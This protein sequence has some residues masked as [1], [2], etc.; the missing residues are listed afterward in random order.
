MSRGAPTRF[1]RAMRYVSV[2]AVAVLVG[3]V[4]FTEAAYANFPH[5]RTFEVSLTG[6]ALTGIAASDSGAEVAAAS[7]SVASPELPDLLFTWTEVGVGQPDVV[8]LLQSEVTA[9]FGCVNA[10][11]KLP[12]AGNKITVAA[13][14]ATE[15]TLT[16][17]RNG[18]ISGSVVLDT[19]SVF[20][21]GFSCPS[22]Q[23]LVALSA[24][25][26]QNT[27]TDTT[28]GVTATDDDIVVTLF[29]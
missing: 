1:A 6:T 9:T 18:K 7:A 19:S 15:A 5:F 28:N 26:A 22:G 14:L 21:T 12:Q 4:G 20:P 11:S 16:S 10:A 2:L 17:D 25:F 13:P 23:T 3:I 8:Y 29:P 24:T 27:I